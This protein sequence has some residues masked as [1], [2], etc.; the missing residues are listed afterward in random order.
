MGEVESDFLRWRIL[1]GV[2]PGAASA[3]SSNLLRVFFDNKG[4]L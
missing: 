1:T 2:I 3:T 4:V